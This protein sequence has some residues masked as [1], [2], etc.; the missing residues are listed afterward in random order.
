[1]VISN[2]NL[3]KYFENFQFLNLLIEAFAISLSI[4]IC[5]STEDVRQPFW[6][7]SPQRFSKDSSVSTLHWKLF[8]TILEI[9]LKQH[10]YIYKISEDLKTVMDNRHPSTVVV[11]FSA[12]VEHFLNKFILKLVRIPRKIKFSVCV[13]MKS[14]SKV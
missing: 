5:Y 11:S 2:D 1:M 6:W 7:V 9:I 10:L 13:F 4:R 3:H 12:K 8:G 14:T